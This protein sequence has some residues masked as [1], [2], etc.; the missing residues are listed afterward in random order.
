[1]DC[2]REVPLQ[3]AEVSKIIGNFLLDNGD[4]FGEAEELRR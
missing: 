1:V 3:E 2:E 4:C